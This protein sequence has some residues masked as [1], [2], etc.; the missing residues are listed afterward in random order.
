VSAAADKVGSSPGTQAPYLMDG[1]AILFGFL[2]IRSRT[3]LTP[4]VGALIL[5][6]TFLRPMFDVG[7]NYA[8]DTMLRGAGD[9]G[10]LFSGY[11]HLAVHAG[12]WMLMFFGAVGTGFTIMGAKRTDK[13]ILGM[14]PMEPHS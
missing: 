14:A 4:F 3:A 5:T 2:L 11:P 8:A 1:L 6:L 7:T 12:A 9:F 10:F 13:S